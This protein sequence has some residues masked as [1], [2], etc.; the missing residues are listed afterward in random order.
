MDFPDQPEDGI[1]QGKPAYLYPGVYVEE[2]SVSVNHSITDVETGTAAF[3]GRALQGPVDVQPVTSWGE[4][5]KI[6]GT[7]SPAGSY[8]AVSVRGFFEN[9][10]KKCLVLRVDDKG[11]DDDFI[12]GLSVLKAVELNILCAPGIVS[13]RVQRAMLDHCEEL[14]DRVCILDPPKGALVTEILAMRRQVASL[15]GYGALYYP[16]IRL[17]RTM[18]AVPPSGHVAGLYAR[19]GAERGVHKA[20]AG[21]DA[22]LSGVTGLE[23]QINK[24]DHEKLNSHGINCIRSIPGKGIRVWGARTLADDPEWKYVNIRRFVLSIERSIKLGIQWAVFE[25]A[26]ERLWMDVRRSIEIFL[27][28]MWRSGALAGARPEEAYFVKCD[29]TTMTQDDTTNG[30][31]RCM[32]GIALFKPAEFMIIGI[33][34]HASP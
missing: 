27:L 26:N 3:L 19:I 6:Y 33:Q 31:L 30:T 4:F 10:G 8:L 9:Q 23:R 21:T 24:A 15:H 5:Q 17:R 28:N 16:W 11:T 34:Q 20:P 25:P 14:R 29:R 13:N 2:Q 12:A 18:A 22:A 1:K 7:E 32:I